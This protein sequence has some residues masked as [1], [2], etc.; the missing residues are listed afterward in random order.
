MVWFSHHHL[1]NKIEWASVLFLLVITGSIFWRSYVPGTFLMGW[2]SVM[3]E[4]NLPVAFSRAV[5]G[6]WQQFQGLGVQGGHG[7]VSDLVRLPGL[8]VLSH[9]FP[10]SLIR[11]VSIYLMWCGGI[12]GAYL[13]C[14]HLSSHNEI[15]LV[16][17]LI[18][19]LHPYTISNFFVIHDAF[20]WLFLWLPWSLWFLMLIS[21]SKSTSS[22]M[23]LLWVLIQFFA[24][25]IGFIPPSFIGYGLVVGAFILGQMLVNRLSI[26]QGLLALLLLIG[27]NLYWLLPFC[28]YTLTQS[29]SYVSAQLNQNTTEDNVLKSRAYGHLDDLILGRNYYFESLDVVEGSS[30]PIM[31]V[32]VHWWAQPWVKVGLV[33]VT[34]FVLLGLC[35]TRRQLGWILGFIVTVVLLCI[36]TPPFS[37]LH[38]V[39]QSIPMLNQAFRIPFTKLSFEY[40]LLFAGM[41]VL[42]LDQLFQW[43]KSKW[44]M[45]F[46]VVVGGCVILW[47]KPL[48]EGKFFYSKLHVVIPPAYFSWIDFSK[49]EVAVH[50]RIAVFPIHTY[51]GWYILNWGYV[52]SGFLFYGTQQSLLDRTFDVWSS[53]NEHYYNVLSTAWYGCNDTLSDACVDRM[54]SLLSTYQVAYVMMDRSVKL[55]KETD[56]KYKLLQTEHLFDRIGKRVFEETP[57]VVWKLANPTNEAAIFPEEKSHPFSLTSSNRLDY[58]D[59]SEVGRLRIT[60]EALKQGTYT[61]QFPSITSDTVF[62]GKLRIVHTG[63]SLQVTLMPFGEVIL[64]TTHLPMWVD[65][66]WDV[67]L[68][69]SLQQQAVVVQAAD[70]LLMAVPVDE[71]RELWGVPL[72]AGEPVTLEVLSNNVALLV[73]RLELTADDWQ[74][75][76]RSWTVSVSEAGER[77]DLLLYTTPQQAMF[78]TD[79]RY[80]ID[81]NCDVL[82]RGTIKKF[83]HSDLLG[84]EYEATHFGA[85]CDGVALPRVASGSAQWVTVEGNNVFGRSIKM[86][87]FS[88]HQDRMV[89]ESVLPHGR[90]SVSFYVPASEYDDQYSLTAETRSYGSVESTNQLEKIETT[91][92][93]SRWL[94]GIQFVSANGQVKKESS[95]HEM[96]NNQGF[97]PGWVAWSKGR[98][99]PHVKA[100]GWQNGWIL[101]EGVSQQDVLIVFWPQYLEWIGFGVMG[102]TIVLLIRKIVS[103][104]KM[105]L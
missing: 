86:N 103:G 14:R 70:G 15:S 16:G 76:N 9:L 26:K 18:Y 81:R 35:Q 48:A 64:G 75:M 47:A 55:S 80:P 72:R 71:E 63:K 92:I 97:N 7:Y 105:G 59:T 29:S 17:A 34:G 87:L 46:V 84:V 69:V 88:Y 43:I 51:N 79:V 36:E 82:K 93:P 62:S 6:V 38:T 56:Q 100:N 25:F 89:Q 99:L 1:K 31:S 22:R 49:R 66:Q 90:F 28:H 50:D 67:L 4:F 98:I 57:L 3:S 54:Q 74:K 11:Y 33:F 58:I 44:M 91:L 78:S 102:V 39:M 8:W 27:S 73:S 104:R 95:V 13:L 101:P 2:D 10:L 83:V 21:R 65:K 41:V 24:S 45:G 40:A 68:P 94:E 96:T 30:Q 60:G 23:W 53:E 12:V 20:G 42:G 37:W 19:G 77:A 52:G 61:V 85:L 32:W 5:T